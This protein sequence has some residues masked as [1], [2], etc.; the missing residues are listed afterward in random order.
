MCLCT[1]WK[2]NIGCSPK[3]I[4][5]YFCYQ[6]YYIS[7]PPPLKVRRDQ[8]TRLECFKTW[9]LKSRNIDFVGQFWSNHVTDYGMWSFYSSTGE[10]FSLKRLCLVCEDAALDGAQIF[11]NVCSKA[12]ALCMENSVLASKVCTIVES[13][14]K[15]LATTAVTITCHIPLINSFEKRL[16]SIEQIKNAVDDEI[17]SIQRHVAAIQPRCQTAKRVSCAAPP[18]PAPPPPPPPPSLKTRAS[19]PLPKIPSAPLKVQRT[20]IKALAGR[21][22]LIQELTTETHHER[23]STTPVTV[24]P[25]PVLTLA[26][27]IAS[28]RILKT[29]GARLSGGGTLHLPVKTKHVDKTDLVSIC[30]AGKLSAHGFIIYIFE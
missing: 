3:Y 28:R 23:K 4:Y 30:S 20:S 13:V 22:E 1:P 11:F 14:F 27:S 6:L 7:Y 10:R 19:L 24:T 18:P 25:K 29:T 8:L 26:E 12:S 17:S 21:E 15:V 2:H 5:M 16:L 9:N